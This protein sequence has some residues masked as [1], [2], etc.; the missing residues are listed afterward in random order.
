MTY[1]S[2]LT[3]DSK[4]V[5]SFKKVIQKK[6]HGIVY[7][8]GT[9]SGILAQFASKNAKEVYAIEQNPFIIKHTKKN[10]SKYNNI[11]LIVTDA[12][13]YKFP[14]EADVII[15]EMLDTALI[16]EEQVPVINNAHKYIK[17]DTIFIPKSVYTTIELISTNI[18]HITYYEDNFPE[19]I[20]LSDEVK[21]HDVS[22]LQP[23][24]E[25]VV[26]EVS[27]KV[28]NEG[29]LNAI[30]LTTYTVLSDDLILEPTSMLNPPILVPVDN[31]IV[32][33]D[34]EIILNI[35]YIMGGG[36]NTIQT[37]IQRNS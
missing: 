19:Y 17:D 20:S 32:K 15:C 31:I 5:T 37:S 21:Y 30:K 2:D 6:S 1:Y 26:K 3:N 10:L 28:K 23:I 36:L 22:F 14:K 34:D 4:R 11:E 7:D 24:E 18:N 35:K 8:L 27:L 13:N 25:L 33:E 12:T 16:D 29:K 9:G